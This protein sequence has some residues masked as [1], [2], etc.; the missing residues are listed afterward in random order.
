MEC[1]TKYERHCLASKLCSTE[2]GGCRI[3]GKSGQINGSNEVQKVAK[4]RTF[5][6]KAEIGDSFQVNN[7]GIA[8]NVHCWKEKTTIIAGDSMLNGLD[9]R[10]LGNKGNVK[11]RAFPGST[12][13]D[14]REHYIQ[15]LLKKRP[16]PIIIHAGT[17]D[18]SQEGANA[19]E[20]LHALLH[21]KAEVEKNIE[22]CKVILS[23]PTQ[24]VDKPSANKII[25]AVNKK[26]Q[27]LATTPLTIITLIE[28]ISDVKVCILT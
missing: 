18:A 8:S 5:S 15:P 1:R 23:L 13:A 27:A 4:R 12:I 2:G 17:N 11:V 3:N 6:E 20:I 26:I 16:S 7:A 24:R 28:M 9:E 14:L 25:Q 22:G 19:D 10:R 21:L